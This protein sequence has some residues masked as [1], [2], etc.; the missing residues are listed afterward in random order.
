M[1]RGQGQGGASGPRLF[2]PLLSPQCRFPLHRLLVVARL[3]EGTAAEEVAGGCPPRPQGRGGGGGDGA[4]SPTLSGVVEAE[5]AGGCS[6]GMRGTPPAALGF[7]PRP[8]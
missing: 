4:G 2:G 7:R 8:S 1:M 6:A 3:G 5:R